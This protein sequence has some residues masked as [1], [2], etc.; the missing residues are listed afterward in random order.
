MSADEKVP[1]T[2]IGKAIQDYTDGGIGVIEILVTL[3]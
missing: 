2:I 1:G 3:M